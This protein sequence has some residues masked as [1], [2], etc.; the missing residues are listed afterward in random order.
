[1]NGKRRARGVSYVI[2]SGDR[3]AEYAHDSVAKLLIDRAGVVRYRLIGHGHVSRNDGVQ[4]LVLELL[5]KASK[6]AKISKEDCD[7]SSLAGWDIL[8]RRF[9]GNSRMRV[10]EFLVRPFEE[11]RNR[12]EPESPMTD[13]GDAHVAQI[14]SR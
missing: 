3:N 10:G 9:L 14:I 1:M 8:E 2:I 5:R 7:G 12:I 13:G 4:R 11:G 6:A